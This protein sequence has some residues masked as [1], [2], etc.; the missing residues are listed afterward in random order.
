MTTTRWLFTT[1]ALALGAAGVA[2]TFAP[3]EILRAFGAPA[4]PHLVVLAQA[5]GA[6][7]LGFAMLNWMARGLLAGG[8]YGRP[9]VVGNLAHFAVMSFALVRVLLDTPSVPGPWLT[10]AIYIGFAAW[11]ARVMLTVPKEVT[12]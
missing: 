7:Y 2:L 8:V 3:H 4:E 10:A 11:F 5:A 12:R 6:L 1:S 9:I